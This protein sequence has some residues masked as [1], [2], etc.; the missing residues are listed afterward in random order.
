[1]KDIEEQ[2]QSDLREIARKQFIMQKANDIIMATI[3]GALA[4][5]KVTAQTGI[6]AIAAAP[7]TSALVGAQIA[8]I[9]SQK[10]VGEKGGLTPSVENQGTLDVKKFAEGGMVHGPS[11]DAGGVKFASGGRVVELEGGE[12]V[13]NKR[14]TALFKPMLSQMNSHNGYGKKFAQGGMTPGT[15]AVMGQAMENWTARDIAGLVSD[16]INSQQVFVTEADVSSSQ[17]VVDIIEA[18]STIF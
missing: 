5:T 3:N 6:G 7:I 15:T 17:S 11:H 9:A 18:Q 13:I 4:I 10:F 14:S 2:K 1:M 16:S 12:A 8:A